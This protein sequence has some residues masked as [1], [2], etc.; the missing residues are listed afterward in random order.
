LEFL[1]YHGRRIFVV[2]DLNIAPFAIDRCDAG[3]EFENNE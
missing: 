3:P 2:G 1:L